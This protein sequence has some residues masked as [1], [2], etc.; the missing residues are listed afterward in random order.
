MADFR[1]YWK[2]LQTLWNGSWILQK[3]F[4]Y[5]SSTVCVDFGRFRKGRKSAVFEQKPWAIAHGFEHGGFS[6]VLEIAPNSLKRLLNPSKMIFNSLRDRLCR[7]RAISQGSK[8]GR[9]WAKTLGYSPR[10][11]TWRIF[12]GTGNRSK[13]SE[14][15]PEPIKMTFNSLRDRLCRFR[16]ISQGSKIGRFLAKTLGYSPRFWTWRI[17]EITGN[18]SKLSET[19]PEPLKNDF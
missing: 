13:L 7:F 9:F 4:L 16:A 15:P 17:F 19:A 18:R 6:K 2:S 1:K 3:W 11:W 12:E 5:L 14:T 8:I 10:F